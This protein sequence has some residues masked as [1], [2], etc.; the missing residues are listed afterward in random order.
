MEGVT[1]MVLRGLEG[2]GEAEGVERVG[3]ERVGLE[4]GVGG[5]TVGVEVEHPVPM[6]LPVI[7]RVEAPCSERVLFPLEKVGREEEEGEDESEGLGEELRVTAPFSG[8]EGVAPF[9][10]EGVGME[11]ALPPFPSPLLSKSAPPEGEMEG[12]M[13]EVEVGWGE[14][15]R[16]WEGEGEKVLDEEEVRVGRVEGVV[17]VD[18]DALKV[19]PGGEGVGV[20][21]GDMDDVAKALALPPFN[22]GPPA[23]PEGKFVAVPMKLALTLGDKDG[24][25]VGE[26]PPPGEG[27]ESVGGEGEGREE[28]LPPPLPPRASSFSPL[29]EGGVEWE[30]EEVVVVE[31]DTH[32]LHVCVRE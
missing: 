27:E 1:V 32:T 24:E 13:V 3:G 15:E 14:P 17:V 16:V 22:P 20:V 18:G 23:V 21:E 31:E 5:M 26:L 2:S 19:G 29:G 25:G 11:D 6:A 28:G 8:G 7:V 9:K 10:L 12:E 30:E 4:E